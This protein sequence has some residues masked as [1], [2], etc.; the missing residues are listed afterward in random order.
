MIIGSAITV[1]L[2]VMRRLF[3]WWPLHPIGYVMAGSYSI[4]HLWWPTFI[5]WLAKFSVLKFGGLRTYQKL[6]PFFIGLVLGE[7]VVVGGWVVIDLILGTKGNFLF[8]L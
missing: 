3:L 4:Y 7:C 2:F 6:K 5:G 8:W 1:F